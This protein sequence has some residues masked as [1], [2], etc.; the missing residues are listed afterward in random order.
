[1]KSVLLVLAASALGMG[2]AS[3]QPPA[4]LI[5]ARAAYQRASTGEGAALVTTDLHDAKV[6]LNDAE[7][8][9]T[10]DGD[11]PKTQSLAYIA[12]RRSVAAQ[13]KAVTA[14]SLQD[15][16]VAEAQFDKFKEQQALA[17]RDQLDST[18]NALTSAQ[19][20][21]EAE[22]R[23]RT[24]ADDK[25]RDL[26]SQIKGLQSQQTERG[27]VLTLSGSVLFATNRSELLP[28]AKTR[29]NEVSKALKEDK[30][31]IVVVGHTDSTGGAELNQKLSNDRASAVRTYLL[32]QGVE[33]SRLRSEGMGPS[34]PVADNAS[35]EGRANNRRVEIILE[36]NGQQQGG[37]LNQANPGM[38]GTGSNTKQP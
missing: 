3:A 10:E 11:E 29:L 15:K 38:N 32:G 13:A 22:R 21:A 6:A 36:N 23:A 2:C 17:T 9:F 37:A 34:Q 27:L 33:T 16:R 19:Q 31:S 14:K 4:Q 12:H 7:Q 30:R 24:A 8:A 35:P 26:L 18:K 1:M 28:T 25:T 20:Q 5:D